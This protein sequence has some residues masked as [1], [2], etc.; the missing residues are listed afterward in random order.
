MRLA[1][2]LSR[3]GITSRRKAE[4]L[5]KE[6]RVEV[7]G[8][9]ITVPQRQV[10]S[11]DEVRVSGRRVSPVPEFVYLLLNKPAGYLTTV[12]DSRG[13][14]TI[15]DLLKDVE[16]R[17]FPVG[18]LDRDTTGLLLLTNDGELAHKLTHPG[19]GIPKTYRVKVRGI[20][21]RQ[22][23]DR[24]KQGIE[25]E[26]GTTAPA[27]VR[28]LKT[29]QNNRNAVLEITLRQGWKRQVRRMCKAI[30][31][32][33]LKLERTGFASLQKGNLPPGMLRRLTAAE[34]E[35]LRKMTLREI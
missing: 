16:E 13:R 32:P 20:P 14:P 12:A 19:F 3:S 29:D 31:Y 21:A 4:Q 30:G 1:K 22:S 28:F 7:N 33:V 10:S 17:V 27:L 34:I 2:F 23:L 35:S 9:C 25:L 6:G 18:R 26:E 24:L 15:F 8:E 11:G 5:I